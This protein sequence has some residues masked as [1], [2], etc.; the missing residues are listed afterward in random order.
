MF[1]KHVIPTLNEYYDIL[2]T[3]MASFT[4]RVLL[5]AD[6]SVAV[7]ERLHSEMAIEGFARTIVSNDGIAYDLPHAEYNIS[8]NL[9][10]WGVLES[11]KR[12]AARVSVG[13]QILVTESAGRSWSNLRAHL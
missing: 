5:T 3:I 9:D 8:S 2:I 13:A 7:Y 1:L 11:A 12:A 6:D 10:K 4:T